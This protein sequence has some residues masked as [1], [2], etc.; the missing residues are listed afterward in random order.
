MLS[1]TLSQLSPHPPL[2]YISPITPITP[3]LTPLTYPT[4][5]YHSLPPNSPIPQD[6][7]APTPASSTVVAGRDVQPVRN[8]LFIYP[9]KD[10]ESASRLTYGDRA[11]AVRGE[12]VLSVTPYGGWSV[13]GRSGRG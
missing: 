2:T 9:P 1:L 8:H 6:P 4:Y 11:R 10:A 12:H 3:Q 5:L 13:E 7:T